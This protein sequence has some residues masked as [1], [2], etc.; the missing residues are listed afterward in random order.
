MKEMKMLE[1]A[2]EFRK[3][4]L[5]VLVLF[6]I[7]FVAAFSIVEQIYKWFVDRSDIK[8]TVLGPT[9]ILWVYFVLAGAFA[10]VAIFPIALFHLWH[11]ISPALSEEERKG[12]LLYLPPLLFSFLVGVLFGFYILFPNVMT[13]LM[14]LAGDQMNTMFT[15]EK[16]FRFLLNL[17]LPIGFLF[18]LPIVV[19]FLTRIGLLNPI[20]LT[21]ARKIAYLLLTILSTLV[22]PPDLIS[23]VLVAIPLVLLYELGILLSRKVYANKQREALKTSMEVS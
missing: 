2:T 12:F 19:M 22:T 8:L 21:K 13:F 1:H 10:L 11:F 5:I 17:T 9:D 20:Q 7:F 18:E 16:Y 14:S 3:R 4:L 15:A 23:A 6:V